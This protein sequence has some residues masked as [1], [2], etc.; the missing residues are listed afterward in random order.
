MRRQLAVGGRE[1]TQVDQPPYPAARAAAANARAARRSAS[2]KSPP[3]SMEWI[4]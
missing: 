2:L 4:R 3:V 1:A